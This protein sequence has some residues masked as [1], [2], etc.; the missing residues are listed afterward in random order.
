MFKDKKA[1]ERISN[2][3][4]EADNAE[5]RFN[6]GLDLVDRHSIL[7]HRDLEKRVATLESMVT[8]LVGALGKEFVEEP[9][10]PAVPARMVVR[11][12]PKAKR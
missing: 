5:S 9:E 10:V 8:L 2:L 3:V 4:Q 7:R 1:H 6:S 11:D 12:L